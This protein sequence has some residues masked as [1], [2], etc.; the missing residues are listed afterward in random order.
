MSDFFAEATYPKA[1]TKHL[2]SLC[3]RIIDPGETYFRQGGCYDGRMYT[4]KACTQCEK[5]ATTLRRLGFENDEGGWPWI[6]ELQHD[7]VAYVGYGRELDLWRAKWRLPDG[8]LYDWPA[9]VEIRRHD[10]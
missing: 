1:R 3:D 10:A 4:V 7:E 5:F 9:D 2:C 6:E 8:T